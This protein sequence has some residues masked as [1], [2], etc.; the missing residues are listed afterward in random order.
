M[1]NNVHQRM[2]SSPPRPFDRGCVPCACECWRADVT[3]QPGSKHQSPK[4]TDLD[5]NNMY[6]IRRH[7]PNYHPYVVLCPLVTLLFGLTT[8]SFCRRLSCSRVKA[9]HSRRKHFDVSF[10]RSAFLVVSYTSTAG[11]EGPAK[12]GRN[13]QGANKQIC[14]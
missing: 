6:E 11:S 4:G 9:E 1:H 12:M 8:L 13:S 7:Y 10:V 3:C 5:E 14:N 2:E